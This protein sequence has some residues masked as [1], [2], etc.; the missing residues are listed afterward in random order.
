MRKLNAD[1]KIIDNFSTG[2]E[3]NV[4]DFKDIGIKIFNLDITNQA[5]DYYTIIINATPIG[6]CPNTNSF[7]KIP[8]KHLNENY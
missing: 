7:P 3:S 2:N 8:Y 6:S 5:N 1:V 4:H